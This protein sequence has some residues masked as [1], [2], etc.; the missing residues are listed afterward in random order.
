LPIGVTTQTVLFTMEVKEQT[1]FDQG[2]ATMATVATRQRSRRE[3]PVQ[4]P[5]GADSAG[6]RMTASQ[7]DAA[8]F[9]EGWRYELIDGVLVVSPIPAEEESSPNDY[10]GYMLW[11]YRNSHPQGASLNQTM[12]ERIVVTKR[13]RRRPD[14]V[15]WAGLGRHPKRKETPT[16]IAEFVSPGKRNRTRDYEDKRDEF[17]EIRV[18]EYWVI[19]RFDRTLTV[20]TKQGSRV[21]KRVIKESEVY[22]TP[23]LPGFELPLAKLLALCDAWKDADDEHAV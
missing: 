18:S 6:A 1:Q 8:D 11:H 23:L 3:P 4:F 16:I 2:P 17:M 22:T 9:E 21:R 13:N 7:F 5:L 19:D 12:P 20:F 10:L 14:R 15:I